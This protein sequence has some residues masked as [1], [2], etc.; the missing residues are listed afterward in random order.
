MTAPTVASLSAALGH[1]LVAVAGFEA[2]RREIS[3]VHISEL[4]EPDSYL[5]GGE[6]LLTTGLAL[7]EDVDGCASYVARLHAAD[8]SALA[9]G[10]GPVHQ[11][12]PA[13]LV[14]ACRDLGV[15][16]LVVPPA[17]PFLTISRS[18]WTAQSRS[19]EERL[20]DVVAAHRAL[21]E[22]AAAVDPAASL[23]ARLARW[24]DGW[25][26]LL[27][28][29]GAVDLAHPLTL[30]AEL[31]VLEAEVKRL[32]MAGVH[33]SASFQVADHI[34]V[35]FPL[36]VGNHVV[37]YLAAGS[38]RRLD[39]A[40]RRVVLTAAALLSLDAVRQQQVESARGATRRCVAVL[41]DLG[42]VDAARRLAAES[43]CASPTRQ[44]AIL[45]V[46][47]RDSELLTQTVERWCAEALTVA[48]DRTIAWCLLPDRHPKSEDLRRRL[49]AT[50][51]T[52]SFALSDLVSVDNA[53]T[54]RARLL[55]EIRAAGAGESMVPRRGEDHAVA[56]AVDAFLAAARPDLRA[57][58][59]AHL[60]HRGQWEAAAASLDLHRNTLRYRVARAVDLLGLDLDD[61]DV[62]AQT[63]LALRACGAT[64]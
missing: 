16:L 1:H 55:Q 50:D 36:A 58:L 31:Q 43:R 5:T 30:G 28:A 52:A 34:A 3:A 53:G 13:V 62:A 35:M 48:V 6:L 15:P 20:N 39:A 19:T 38:P 32:D 22:A 37:G 46:R 12:P 18:Y 45:V 14:A 4:L 60:R 27:D 11:E 10:L 7:P 25:A 26:V 56:Q 40:Q 23:L 51:P 17:T 47:G 57:A 9:L 44:V 61:P 54:V 24:L 63:W 41:V 49:D 8:I 33:S 64:T 2:P 59:V 21:V 42:L 29:S